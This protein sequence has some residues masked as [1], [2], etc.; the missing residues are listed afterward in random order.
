[1][2]IL[3]TISQVKCKNSGRI[4]CSKNRFYP[5]NCSQYEA[6]HNFKRTE[7]L[8]IYLSKSSQTRLHD[9][10]DFTKL[11]NTVYYAVLLMMNDQI[12]SKHVEQKLWNKIDY[13]NCASHWLLTHCNMMHGAHNVKL[14]PMFCQHQMLFNYQQCFANILYLTMC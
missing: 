7:F 1:M 14:S 10:T 9:C 6:Q 8:T 4:S 2:W 13:K 5:F 3:F 11:C 12:R